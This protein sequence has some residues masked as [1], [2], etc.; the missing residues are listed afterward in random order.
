MC[1]P[2]S[3]TDWQFQPIRS[4]AS[5]TCRR[6]RSPSKS[7]VRAN[8]LTAFDIVRLWAIV[9]VTLTA[10]IGWSFIASRALTATAGIGSRRGVA[11][12]AMCMS[13]PLRRPGDGRRRGDRRP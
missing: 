7:T 13:N 1:C 2:N 10:L 6:G 11:G 12:R 9:A 8:V 3:Y 5:S 4:T